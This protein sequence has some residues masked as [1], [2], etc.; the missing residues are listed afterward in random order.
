[1]IYHEGFFD[2]IKWK[3][4]SAFRWK[5][6]MQQNI[7]LFMEKGIFI[8]AIAG[9]FFISVDENI[10]ENFND[11]ADMMDVFIEKTHGEAPF[12]VYGVIENKQKIANLKTNKE[13]L[14]HLGD[15]KKWVAQNG[16]EFRLE[17]LTEIKNNVSYLI[18]EYAYFILTK[19][20]GMTSYSNLQLGEVHYLDY[21]DLSALKEIE[22]ALSEQLK[23]GE[24]VD[25]LLSKLVFE[26]LKKQEFQEEIYAAPSESSLGLE[27]EILPKPSKIK[28]IL[29][30]IRLGIRR[31][32]PNCFNKD[33]NKIRE[34]LDR[35]H[36]LMENP[37]IYG[38]KLICGLCGHEWKTKK[39][40]WK[41][42][43]DSESN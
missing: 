34:V 17:N 25:Q 20:K 21:H 14:K 24:T 33:R 12:L 1:L 36:I 27:P 40:E 28:Q 22:A 26:L 18:N 6:T 30:E 2:I 38:W 3:T 9:I 37:N 11:L 29:E 7:E 19:F 10:Y 23:A 13:L 39:F 31:Q 41:S 16:G 8:G 4:A 15:V 35:E 43:K 32:C 5:E 42:Q